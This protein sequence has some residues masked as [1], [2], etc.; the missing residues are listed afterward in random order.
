MRTITLEEHFVTTDFLKVTEPY[1]PPSP[2]LKALHERLLDLGAGR[3]AAIFV[4][5]NHEKL[6]RL[7]QAGASAALG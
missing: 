6:G 3:I 7:S 2:H 1:M 5:R 4:V